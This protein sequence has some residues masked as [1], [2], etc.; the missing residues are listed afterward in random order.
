MPRWPQWNSPARTF[1]TTSR[2]LRP[3]WR[4]R[5]T[6]RTPPERAGAAGRGAPVSRAVARLNLSAVDAASVP[7]APA[8][9]GW[10]EVGALPNVDAL[11]HRLAW[12]P[13]RP[14]LLQG[15]CA[16]GASFDEA[17]RRGTIC[18]ERGG[19][20]VLDR[21]AP[22]PMGCRPARRAPR[23]QNSSTS[24]HL[25]VEQ[26][27]DPSGKLTW[28]RRCSREGLAS[29]DELGRRSGRP[30]RCRPRSRSGSRGTWP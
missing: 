24:G 17:A 7:D 6:T 30:S 26:E 18:Q 12:R 8:W 1:T 10:S 5:R 22:P 13:S 19:E 11:D 14:A 15:S 20:G 16:G 29:D 3:R 27:R 9:A 25:A 4:R 23:S 21:A 28:G 2:I